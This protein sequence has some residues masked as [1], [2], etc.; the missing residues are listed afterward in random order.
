MIL[1]VCQWLSTKTQFTAK[2]IRILFVLLV[3][4]AGLGL[5]A[6]LILWLVKILSKE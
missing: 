5:G 2:N 6:Y 3:L 1:G 4:F